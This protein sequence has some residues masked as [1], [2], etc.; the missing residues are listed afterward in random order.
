MDYI[1]NRNPKLIIEVNRQDRAR[2]VL[3]NRLMQDTE[4]SVPEDAEEPEDGIRQLEIEE[5]EDE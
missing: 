3:Q 5:E 4:E 2:P 1:I